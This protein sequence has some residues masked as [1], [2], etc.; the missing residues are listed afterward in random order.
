M[1]ALQ[2]TIETTP[3]YS[4]HVLLVE[5]EPSV[6]KGLRMVLTQECYGIV[7]TS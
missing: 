3:K 5:D 7:S 6:A 2:E 1:T 4:H